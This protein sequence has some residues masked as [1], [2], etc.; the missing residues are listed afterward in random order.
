MGQ[1][2]SSFIHL[3]IQS[4]IHVKFFQYLLVERLSR[5]SQ[6]SMKSEHEIYIHE[7]TFGVL[8]KYRTKL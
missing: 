1:L 4:F 6:S 7:F 2:L 5:S 3:E 8:S